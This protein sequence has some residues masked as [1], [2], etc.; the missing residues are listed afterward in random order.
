MDITSHFS[1]SQGL[2][3]ISTSGSQKYP[4]KLDSYSSITTSIRCSIFNKNNKFCM[5]SCWES[6]NIYYANYDTG[7]VK[8]VNFSGTELASLAL[9]TP[10]MVSVI[11]DSSSMNTV[12]TY[13]PQEDKGCWIAD[14]DGTIIKTDNQLNV[15]YQLSGITNATGI[16]ADLDGGCYVAGTYLGSNRLIKLSTTAT[17]LATKPYASFSPAVSNFIEMSLDVSNNLWFTAND[18]IYSVRYQNG[19]IISLLPSPLDPISLLPPSVEEYHIGGTDVDRNSLLQYLYVTVGNGLK[20][21][22]IK[23]DQDG[24]PIA[25]QLY[26]DIVY[27]YI[28][29]VVQGLASTS[30]YILEDS[31]K[32][33]DYGYGSS[34]SSSSSSYIENWSSSSSSSSSSSESSSSESS[35]SSSS[36]E[37]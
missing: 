4:D 6:E 32:W 3:I 33:D 36:S 8:K 15:L 28:I 12:V 9:T 25:S 2:T 10:Y 20:S 7:Y 37:T 13:P 19:Q 35:S 24:T 16:I 29:K 22:I 30:L 5:D 31:A 34:S 21:Y 14:A 26:T 11:Q 18:K 27:P 17:V 23:Y 1:P